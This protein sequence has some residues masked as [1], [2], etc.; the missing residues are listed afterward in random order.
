MKHKQIGL[1][2]NQ[3]KLPSNSTQVK[4][5]IV[6]FLVFL[7]CFILQCFFGEILNDPEW[8]KF[9]DNMFQTTTSTQPAF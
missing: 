1:F 9:D 4:S 6:L 3:V 2:S 5:R 8:V 7:L